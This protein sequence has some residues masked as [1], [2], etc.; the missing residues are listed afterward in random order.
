MTDENLTRKQLVAQ[1]FELTQR[2][3]AL[4]ALEAEWARTAEA[5][6]ASEQRFR[7]IVD[8]IPDV[9]VIIDGNGTIQ[10]INHP[11]PGDRDPDVLGTTI[12]DH[13]IPESIDHYRSM[14]EH[15]LQTG[16]FY[17][18]EA[19]IVAGRIY[20]CRCAPLETDGKVEHIIVILTDVTDQRKAEESLERHRDNLENL[21]QDRTASLEEANSALRVMLNTAEQMRTEMHEVV[22]F[23]VK[24]LV[25]PYLEELRRTGLNNRQKSYLELLE[26][27]LTQITQQF[28]GGLPAK[29]LTLTPTELL[30]ANLV[31]EGKTAKEI[32]NLLDLSLRTV[33]N[34][35]YSIRTKLG[36]KR[37]SINLRT[38]LSS[39]GTTLEQLVQND[40]I[41]YKQL[42]NSRNL[43]QEMEV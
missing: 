35:R 15:V 16:E 11:L 26:T 30:V 19:R 7:A 36:L 5:L 29:S 23:N 28:M 24:K 42:L 1:V 41:E 25:I 9:F 10:F 14:A 31:K 18:T 3:K 37:K 38:Y 6:K 43:V 34:H 8:N 4:E 33:E 2:V 20:D 12:Y 32:A 27:S 13:M 17:R 40:R 39:S 21:I 22:L